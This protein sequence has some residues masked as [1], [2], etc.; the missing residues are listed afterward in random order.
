M[1]IELYSLFYALLITIGSLV[2]LFGRR[3]SRTKNDYDSMSWSDKYAT[4]FLALPIT[5]AAMCWPQISVSSVFI[6]TGLLGLVEILIYCVTFVSIVS[7]FT[8]AILIMG[9]PNTL[10][11][12][13]KSWR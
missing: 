7:G 1:D 9:G 12:Q 2:R 5:I 10:K 13:G 6:E 3:L 4:A 8:G 11:A